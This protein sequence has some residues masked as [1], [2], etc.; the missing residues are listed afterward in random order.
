MG[1]I[2]RDR[3]KSSKQENRM[4]KRQELQQQEGA[5]EVQKLDGRAGVRGVQKKEE[6]QNIYF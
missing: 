1:V 2:T 3:S 6:D 4:Y 5:Y